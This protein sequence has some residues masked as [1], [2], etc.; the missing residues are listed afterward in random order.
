METEVFPRTY[1][2]GRFPEFAEHF[3]QG[4]ILILGGPE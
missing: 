3:M 1:L 4:N 2:A